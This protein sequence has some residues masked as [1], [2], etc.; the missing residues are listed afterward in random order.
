MIIFHSV[1]TTVSAFFRNFSHVCFC[2]GLRPQ[3]Q[4]TL[5]T[6]RRARLG[7]S[8]PR[9]R[10]TGTARPAGAPRTRA[11][12]G[13]KDPPPPP[14]SYPCTPTAPSTTTVRTST[15]RCPT[16]IRHPKRTLTLHFSFDSKRN[17]N[18]SLDY[19]YLT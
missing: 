18:Y 13:P 11:M 4:P 7:R 2:S 16:S 19:V 3:R 8:S 6:D 12:R 15:S 14:I 10:R 5:A 9:E 1:G 17:L